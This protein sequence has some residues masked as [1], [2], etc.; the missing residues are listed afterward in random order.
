MKVL[1]KPRC[2]K[3]RG[4]EVARLGFLKDKGGSEYICEKPGCRHP[5]VVPTLK[6]TIKETAATP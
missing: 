5:F 2:P 1:S 3:C 6:F 4:E